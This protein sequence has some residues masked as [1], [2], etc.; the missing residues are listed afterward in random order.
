MA[1][2]CLIGKENTHGSILFSRHFL[3]ASNG[4]IKAHSFVSSEEYK[5]NSFLL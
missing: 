5:D 1:I 4:N 3:L 2:F